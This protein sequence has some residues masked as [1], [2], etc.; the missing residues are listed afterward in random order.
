LRWSQ[1]FC[2][3]D[4]RGPQNQRREED[5]VIQRKDSHGPPRVKIEEVPRFV[6]GIEQ[7]AGDQ[8]AGQHEEQI[9]TAGANI[10]QRHD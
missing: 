3:T 4:K 8:E 10:D 5:R 7:N 2:E 1:F 6:L 9:D